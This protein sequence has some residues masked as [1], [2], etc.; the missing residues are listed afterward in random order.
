MYL[1][2]LLG[3]WAPWRLPHIRLY[4]DLPSSQLEVQYW[5]DLS[6]ASGQHTKPLQSPEEGA[7]WSLLKSHNPDY[8]SIIFSGN[9]L[10]WYERWVSNY[11]Y[12][13]EQLK[14]LSMY[15]AVGMTNFGQCVVSKFS[16][17]TTRKINQCL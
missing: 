8:A 13:Y 3:N 9:Q 1:E 17:D 12:L 10:V 6:S 11:R 15:I 4:P 5:P 16:R 2:N 7:L 14:E